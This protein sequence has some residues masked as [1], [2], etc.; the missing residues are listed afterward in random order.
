MCAIFFERRRGDY[1]GV[2]FFSFFAS[3]FVF[4]QGGRKGGRGGRFFI[5]H[6]RL[7]SVHCTVLP[8][9]RLILPAQRISYF[10]ES[11]CNVLGCLV[12]AVEAL[13]QVAHKA[14]CIEN[15]IV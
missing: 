11:I 1:R 15:Q 9:Y 12:E 6:S 2:F 4:F 14:T 3:F 5:L 10:M 7:H 13:E 8:L